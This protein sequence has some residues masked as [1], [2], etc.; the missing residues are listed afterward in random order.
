MTVLLTLLVV[1]VALV[2]SLRKFG[3]FE[4]GGG[5]RWLGCLLVA[6]LP[7]V[8]AVAAL[9][10]RR[11]RFNL[12]VLLVATALVAFFLFWTVRPLQTAIDSRRAS[13]LLLATGAQLH[14]WSSL[15]E[16]YRQLQYDPRPGKGFPGKHGALP[17]WLRPLAGDLLSVPV[18]ETVIEVW[19]TRDEQVLALCSEGAAFSHL[20]RISVGPDVTKASMETLRQALPNFEYLTDLELLV[21]VRA[22][23]L[24][25]LQGIRTL[26]LTKPFA[27]PPR[28]LSDEQLAAVAEL[29]ELQVLFILGYSNVDADIQILSRSKSLRH[30]VLKKTE[31]TK[32]GEK[33]LSRA[34]P[35]CVIHRD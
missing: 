15:D 25:S 29:P 11:F 33:S 32:A 9:F 4:T 24:R 10:R 2:V 1:E 21:D 19:L 7:L 35:Q 18:D 20:E 17:F 16:T 12:R 5:I 28:R 26:Q 13:R 31:V 6:V 22:D 27:A 34:L 3:W 23:W 14:G 8:V 30:L